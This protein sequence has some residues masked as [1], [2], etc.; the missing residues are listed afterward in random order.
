M[1]IFEGKAHRPRSCLACLGFVGHPL[2]HSVPTAPS[3]QQPNPLPAL[4]FPLAAGLLNC[5]RKIGWGARIS[6]I[7]KKPYPNAADLW[8]AGAASGAVG[9]GRLPITPGN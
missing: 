3:P 8:R 1:D 4:G 2:G 7:G 5:Q 6:S 9:A